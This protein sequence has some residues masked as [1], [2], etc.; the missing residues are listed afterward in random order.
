MTEEQEQRQL[1]KWF[2]LQYP[3]GLCTVDLGGVRLNMGQAKK[4]KA[5]RPVKGHPDLMFQKVFEDGYGQVAYCGL[6]IELKRTG[7]IPYKKNGEI[8]KNTHLQEQYEYLMRLREE[9][10][11]SCFCSGFKEAKEL[12]TAYMDNDFEKLAALKNNIFPKM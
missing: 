1:M 12:I 10:W 3:N 8:K 5:S 9:Y 2:Y 7:E 11:F 6:A 4:L